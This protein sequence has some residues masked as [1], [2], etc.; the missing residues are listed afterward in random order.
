MAAD[1]IEGLA[2]RGCDPGGGTGRD[3]AGLGPAL[4]MCVWLGCIHVRTPL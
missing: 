2:L 1:G 3:W 4:E